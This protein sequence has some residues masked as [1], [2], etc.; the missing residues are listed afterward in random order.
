MANNRS[1]TTA[2]GVFENR[3]D[4][5]RAVQELKR[6]GF[7]DDQIG[8]VSHNADTGKAEH[9]TGSGS[10]VEAGA[11]TGAAAGAGVGALWGLGIMAGLLPAIGPVIA[12]GT[13][14]ALLGSAATGAVAA[15][16]AGALIGMGI[17]D[18]DATYYESE[19]KSGRTI[20]T[21]KAENRY[22]EANNVLRRFNSYDR[23]SNRT[24]TGTATSHTSATSGSSK[25]STSPSYSTA[26]SQA[27][28]ATGART[29][30]NTVELHE[31]QLNV[32]KTPVQTGEVKV[33]KEVHTEHKTIDVPVS[34]EEVVIERTPVHS[35]HVASG[36][37]QAGQEIRIPVREEQV[38]VQKN[39][40]TK[41]E[42]RVG[43][44]KVED[45]KHVSE[46]LRKEDIKVETQGKV[47]VHDKNKRK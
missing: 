13:L 28:T 19:F 26:G 45:T 4:A 37:I 21:V 16:L 20:V 40:V 32:S 18:E 47:D 34:R 27:H 30:G 42:V 5:Q 39:M 43:T 10:N 46:D 8:V 24:S 41:E 31:E 11:L 3:E 23:S 9:T 12:G 15:G 29:G 22:D 25:T 44:R 2:V 1:H 7:R 17:P 35:G 38:N 36:N 6:M 14:A 33:R